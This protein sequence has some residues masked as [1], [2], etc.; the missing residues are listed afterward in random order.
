[1]SKSAPDTT[2]GT[3]DAGDAG[4]GIR[5]V[6]LTLGILESLAERGEVGITDL[7]ARLGSTK[8]TIFRHLQTLLEARYVLRNSVNARYRLGPACWQLGQAAATGMDL[9]AASSDVAQQ[10]LQAHGQTV[11][12]SSV[13]V[14]GI[15]VIN[16]VLSGST[17]EIG[18]RPGSALSLHATAQGKVAAA[19]VPALRTKLLTEPGDSLTEFTIT[20]VDRLSSELSLIEARGWGSA[21]EEMMLGINGLA[22]PIF[23]RSGACVATIAV[24]GSIQFVRRHSDPVQVE[25]VKSAAQAISDRLGWKQSG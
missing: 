24:V 8:T 12:L 7:S 13:S 1:M 5:S 14:D 25:A 15:F 3:N 18:V 9:L 2:D 10:L 22:A 19:F 21:P 4:G 23:D 20:D 16:T 6:Q 17:L 11:V